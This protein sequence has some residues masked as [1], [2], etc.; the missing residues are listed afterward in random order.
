MTHE[1]YIRLFHKEQ[2]NLVAFKMLM[3]CDSEVLR[4]VNAAIAAEREE[5]AQMVDE[6]IE[7]ATDVKA[8]LKEDSKARLIAA[9]AIYQ[10]EKLAAAIR[11]RGEKCKHQ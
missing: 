4:L 10:T 3:D 1:E 8:T 6:E 11:A 7:M 9:G 2:L 5:I